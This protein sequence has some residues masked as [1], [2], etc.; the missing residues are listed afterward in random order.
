M[1]GQRSVRVEGVWIEPGGV[2]GVLPA[3]LGTGQFFQLSCPALGFGL[4][5]A[6]SHHQRGQHQHLVGVTAQGGGLGVKV[7]PQGHRG[8]QRGWPGKGHLGV[9]RGELDACP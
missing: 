3:E 9:A 2:Q 1:R 6:Q 7:G 5:T 8:L 4:G